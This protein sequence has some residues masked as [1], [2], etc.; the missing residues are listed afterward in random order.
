MRVQ[1]LVALI[2]CTL[3]AFSQHG[4]KKSF[5]VKYIQEEIRPDGILDEPVW[6]TAEA[7]DKFWQYFPVD[8]VQAE[9]QSEIK[10]LFDDKN[11]YIGITV[12]TAGKDY[13]IQSLRR[14]FRAGNSDN[15]TLLF[16]TFN[17]ANNAFL[18]GT[19]PYGVRREG[20]VSGGGLDL[21]GFTISWDV[22]WRGDSQ[23]YEDYYTS[24]MVIPLTSFKFREGETRWR[25]NS[26]RF[27]TQSNENSTWAHIPQ[28]QNIFGLTF[29]GDMVFE[30]PLGKSRTPMAFI[31]YINTS[32]FRDREANLE[33]SNFKVGGDAKV[34]IGNSMNL[35]I[36]LNP[37]FSQVEVDDQ[38]TNL[39]RFE[40]ALPEKRQFFIDNIDLFASFG[41]DRDANPFFS[42]RIGI[43]RDT[44]G[45]NIENRIQGGVRLSGKLNNTLRLGFFNIQ[46]EKDVPNGIAANNNTMLSLQQLVFS[47]SNVGFFFINRQATGERDF[48][49]PEDS[50]N[51]VVGMDYNLISSDNIWS[52][53][54][55]AHKSFSPGVDSKDWST[56]AELRFNKRNWNAF[57]KWV[58]IGDDFQSDLGFVRRTD[59]LKTVS[60]FN[61]VFWPEDSFI[62]NHSIGFTPF[63]IWQPS[64]G[65]R[66]TDHNFRL[67][68]EAQFQNQQQFQVS[69]NSRY[70]Y[71]F[72]SFDPTRSGGVELPEDTD[73]YYNNAQVQYRSDR[74]RILSYA[75]ES[76]I[77]RFFNGDRLSV[78]GSVNLRIQPKA[79]VSMQVNYDKISLPEPYS[80]ADIWLIV[81]R[82]ELTFS[83]S[84]FWNTLIQYS[85]QRDNLGINSRLQWRFAPLSDLFLVY[86]DN[87][88]VDR[89]SPRFRSINLKLTYWLNI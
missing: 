11:L 63:V 12:H 76:T 64:D 28:N 27:D 21:N 1:C 16:D 51:R 89:F 46:T 53:R 57:T 22:K 61:R 44:A 42:R 17:D 33:E 60:S 50:Y 54:A 13:A 7:A 26:Y 69:W 59:I 4:T 62:N 29:M 31:P 70:T 86:T 35:D 65:Y 23:I 30:R 74:R 40:V 88:F 24:E 49:D 55:Y 41:D 66:K 73:Y 81:P 83:K 34:S 72:N 58:K 18:F 20:L 36:T 79:V 15:I 45:N 68:Y 39:T 48:L 67:R 56:G 14:D 2:F 85:N 71:L 10:M 75:V 82:F 5:T 37:D 3:S 9:K 6:E 80:S 8:S 43:A 47:R 84:L 32:W 19:N 25:F 38:V 87:Y 52:G 78:E 77:G